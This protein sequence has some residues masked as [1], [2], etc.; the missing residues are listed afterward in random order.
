MGLASSTM[1]DFIQIDWGI[2]K[3]CYEK[4]MQ[5]QTHG[6]VGNILSIFKAGK[7][8]WGKKYCWRCSNRISKRP[9]RQLGCTHRTSSC[10]P[11]RSMTSYYIISYFSP[12]I[13]KQCGRDDNKSCSLH[14]WDTRAVYS[15]NSFNTP[16]TEMDRLNGFYSRKHTR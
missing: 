5:I 13:C 9:W 3:I 16:A 1:A 11:T 4:K 14:V 6:M 2:H 8:K 15:T 12:F 10:T 7:L